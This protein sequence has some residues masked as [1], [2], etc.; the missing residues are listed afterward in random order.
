MKILL[1]D[2]GDL[3]W[4]IWEIL[5]QSLLWQEDDIVPEDT[6]LGGHAMDGEEDHHA[7][8]AD[9]NITEDCAVPLSIRGTKGVELGIEAAGNEP[10][11]RTVR[12]VQ[13]LD[14]TV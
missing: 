6:S 9:F 4:T 2:L 1:N 12:A 8:R 10:E 13:S 14:R 7:V 3:I 5:H 11:V